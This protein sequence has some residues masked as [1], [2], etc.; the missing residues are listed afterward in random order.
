MET[1][2]RILGCFCL[3]TC[4]AQLNPTLQKSSRVFAV[5]MAAHLT[6]AQHPIFAHAPNFSF[7]SCLYFSHHSSS[8]VWSVSPQ[9]MILKRACSSAVHATPSNSPLVTGAWLRSLPASTV[10]KKQRRRQREARI[11]E[12]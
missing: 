5:C 3:C 9:T 6:V 8:Q 10:A 11:A 1:H 12:T 4:D 2:F 7:H